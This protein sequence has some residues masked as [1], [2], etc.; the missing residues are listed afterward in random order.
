MEPAYRR[1]LSECERDRFSAHLFLFLSIPVFIAV[2]YLS[3]S[4]LVSSFWDL[5]SL[6]TRRTASYISTHACEIEP[7]FYP[8][9]AYP[10]YFSQL[11]STIPSSLWDCRLTWNV[12]VTNRNLLVSISPRVSTDFHTCSS[13]CSITSPITNHGPLIGKNPLGLSVVHI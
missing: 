13:N 5:L 7:A 6:K 9:S 3:S 2:K 12:S 4:R 8:A 10:F 11:V 1:F